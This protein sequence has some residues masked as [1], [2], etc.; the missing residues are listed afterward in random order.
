MLS[1]LIEVLMRKSVEYLLATQIFAVLFQ[2]LQIEKLITKEKQAQQ[3]ASQSQGKSGGGGDLQTAIQIAG[4][5][6]VVVDLH[7]VELYLKDNQF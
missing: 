4:H 1:V 3:K 6:L 7:K 5:Y 2:N